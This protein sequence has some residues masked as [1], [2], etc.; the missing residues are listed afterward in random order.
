MHAKDIVISG[1][2]P[3]CFLQR[4]GHTGQGG[5]LFTQPAICTGSPLLMIDISSC[6][7]LSSLL[8]NGNFHAANIHNF[9]AA[10]IHMNYLYEWSS[11]TKTLLKAQFHLPG[12]ETGS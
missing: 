4:D 2:Q 3:G 12:G 6:L 5:G 1:D 7:V 8:V 11:A 9:Y 10:N